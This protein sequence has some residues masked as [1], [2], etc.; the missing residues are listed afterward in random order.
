[1][2]PKYQ[3]EPLTVISTTQSTNELYLCTLAAVAA[4]QGY[5]DTASDLT[6]L[7]NDPA[8]ENWLESIQREVNHETAGYVEYVRSVLPHRAHEIYIGMTSSDLQDTA[9]ALIWNFYWPALRHNITGI[10]RTL[11]KV[12]PTT[13]EGRT[14]G[15]ATGEEVSTDKLYGRAV[16]NL[17]ETICRIDQIPLRANLSGPVGDF[18]EF[19]TYDQAAKAAKT[20]GLSLDTHATQTAD[21]H[22]Y[23]EL[24]FQLTQIVG[25]YEQLATLHRLSSISGVDDYTEGRKVGQMGSSSMPHKT[26]PISAEQVSGLARLAR[27]NLSALLETWRTQWWER[28]LTN[29]S[30]E[31]VAWRD[32]LHLVGYLTDVVAGWD[33]ESWNPDS[34]V[35]MKSTFHEYNQALVDGNSPAEVYR[36]IQRR[37]A[38]LD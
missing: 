2:H 37:A 35:S 8:W 13:R 17:A 22:R 18:S 36:D 28:D 32:L 19:L 9:E 3:H 23:A 14:H 31:R 30:V 38:R 5:L 16:R 6:A 21:R 1:M 34:S 20:L 25:V 10:V 11:I 33:F 29:S 24:A 15:R 12:E 26:N 27:S 7:T 4:S